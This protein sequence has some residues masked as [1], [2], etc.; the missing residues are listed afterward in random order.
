MYNDILKIG[1]LS[2]HGYGLMIGIGVIVALV[3]AAKRAK[4]SGLDTDIVYG[5]GLV[6]LVS[7][8]IGAK[9]LYCFVELESFLHDPMRILSGSGFVLYGGIIGGIVAAMFYCRHK[10]VNFFEYFDLVMPSVALAQGFGRI[11]CFLAGCCYGRET[12]SAIG[13]MFHNSSIA[14]NGVKLIPTQLFSSA[15][16]FLIAI[17]LLLYARKDRKA[18]KVGA[19]YLIFYSMGRF[20]I[21]FFRSDYRGN[22]GVLSTS[23]F[24]SLIILAIGAAMFFIKELPWAKKE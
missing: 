5:L 9:L 10:K 7:G 19:L 11:G 6:T 23:Q 21:E 12:N 4:K 3:V 8:F 2:I 14:P 18:G 15:G 13:V 24:I 17:V 1:S 22:V 20:I 16:N